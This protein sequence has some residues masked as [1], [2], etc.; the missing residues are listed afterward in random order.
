MA[1]LSAPPKKALLPFVQA[2]VAKAG[3]PSLQTARVV[4]VPL[5]GLLVSPPGPTQYWL[6][7]EAELARLNKS[8]TMKPA[9][10]MA[11]CRLA[12]WRG[13]S[14]PGIASVMPEAQLIFGF[15][16]RQNVGYSKTFIQESIFHNSDKDMKCPGPSFTLCSSHASSFI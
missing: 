14:P 5:A 9:T 15:G 8:A 2:A 4:H 13:N 1:L 16:F 10:I 7:A 12:A 11:G 3:V 6:N